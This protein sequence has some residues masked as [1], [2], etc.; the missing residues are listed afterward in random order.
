MQELEADKKE[1]KA[2]KIGRWNLIFWGL[3]GILLLAGVAAALL[4]YRHLQLAEW[5]ETATDFPVRCST[6]TV[7]EKVEAAWQSSRGNERMELRA[8]Y[9][10]TATITI[11]AAQGAGQFM[12]RFVDSRGEFRGEIYTAP[13]QNGSFCPARDITLS[14]DARQATVRLEEGF[15]TKDA[16]LLHS[17]SESEPLWRIYVWHRAEG[18][19]E[20]ALVGFR[21]IQATP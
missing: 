15:D 21:T 4:P 11:E 18:T 20:N 13:Y 12:L 7:L 16:Y 6:G 14:D 2:G 5:R 10:P 19:E 17:L 3:S 9:Y 8:A 1:K